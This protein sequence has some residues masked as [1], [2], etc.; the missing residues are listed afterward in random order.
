[1][2]AQR[3]VDVV[4]D[5]VGGSSFR[6]SYALLAPLGRMVAFGVSQAVPGSRRS[7]WRAARLLLQMPAFRPLSLMNHNRGVFGLNLGRLW[8]E[9]AKL[10]SSMGL[11]L[12]ELE[13]GRLQPIVATTFPLEQ[14]AAAH[15][16]LHER[17]NIGKVLL[18]T[19]AP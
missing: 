8:S 12:A 2:T 3:G 14:A 15:R 16:Y 18:T 17:Q 11:L 9:A 19:T 10:Q 6:D 7:L 13:A 5:P 4:L 1:L